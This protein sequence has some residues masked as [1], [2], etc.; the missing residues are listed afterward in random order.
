MRNDNGDLV[1]AVVVF[2][3][4]A[5]RKQLE[6]TLR[7]SEEKCRELIENANDI[8]YTI[9][10][11]GGF[12]SMNRAGELM[13]GYTREEALGMNIADVIQPNDAVRVRERIAKN[14]A[15]AG[16]PDFELEIFAKDGGSV[17]M[18]ISSRLIVQDGA[19]V[20]IQ[21][22]GRDITDRKR[23]EAELRAREAQLSEAQTIAKMGS[24]E[25]DV[26]TNK[27]NWS[28]AL[29]DI[30]GIQ[31]QDCPP[32]FEGYLSRVHPDDRENIS[33]LV[34]TALNSGQGCSYGHRIIRPDQ[35]IR[36]N[37]VNLR[38]VLD[39]AGRPMKLF[40]TAQDITSRKYAELQ[41]GKYL[42]AVE[43]ARAEAEALRRST[44]ALT[45]NLAMDVVLDTL[46]EC[47]SG[48]VPFD[49]GQVLLLEGDSELLVARS[50]PRTSNQRTGLTL[51]AAS[52]PFLKRILFEHKEVLLSD[53]SSQPEWRD[54]KTFGDARSWLG[55]PLV[56]SGR[57]LGVLS[58]S[59]NVSKA[60]AAEHLRLAKLLSIPAAVAIQN[61][62][63]YER[64]EIYAAELEDRLRELQETRRALKHT[65]H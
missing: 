24:W 15:G 20:G 55:V 2:R 62:R 31:P 9:D 59:I 29:Y 23:A 34:G 30:Y 35:S 28:A 27:T 51:N 26:A 32:T 64:A 48:L 52:H 40:G 43:A 49:S 4:I 50:A 17:T 47:L 60:F 6:N 11:S 8:I 16:A 19:V 56:V 61:A 21:G 5:E 1:G 7:Q 22:I 10:L 38:V 53:T 46:L 58:L 18:D 13:T 12:T 36:F 57:I 14:L 25:W 63:M 3:D 33:E 37:H 41:I 65:D 45:K 44:L 39:E 42:D 54:S